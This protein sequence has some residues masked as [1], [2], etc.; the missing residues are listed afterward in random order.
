MTS[1]RELLR[2][3]AGSLVPLL[4]GPRATATEPALTKR[5]RRR[6]ASRV[7]V[8]GAG[9]FGGWTALNLAQRGATVTLIDAWGAG[10]ARAS[11]GGETR[12]I[13][14]AYNGQRVYIEMARRAL[15]LWREYETAWQRTVLHR[16]G[17]LWMFETGDDAFARTSADPMREMRLM[18]EEV[19]L[20]DA[21]KRFPQIRTDGL[22][23]V[24]WE[25]DA[26]YLLAREACELVRA[27]CVRAGVEYLTG[28]ANAGPISSER[29][30][31]VSLSD[32]T[33]RDADAFVF[34]CGPWLG[35]LF[36]D[37]LGWRIRATKQDV[38]YFGTPAGDR[39]FDAET[40]PVWVNLG[41][42]IMYGIPGN[43][44]R[45]FKIA[46]D[47]LGG[48]VD[49]TSFERTVSPA[50]VM[51]ARAMLR[52]R[53]PLLA[54]APL[55]HAEVCQYE[56]TPDGHYLMDWHPAARN[57]LLLGGGSGHGFKMGPAIGEMASSL[58]L[59]EGKVVPMF[60]YERLRTMTP[61]R[62][63]VRRRA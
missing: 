48:D 22:Q 10:N 45:G 14:A 23:R 47:S 18:L 5:V 7:V 35:A 39:Q 56:S 32:G 3:C 59:S 36:P 31:Y 30:S 42:R 62:R 15:D 43:E 8:V 46:D 51:T 19:S 40:M 11:S 38:L 6:S 20:A 12:V 9:A 44:R 4:F 52:R 1:R 58:V 41:Q 2:W 28:K 16:T 21:A 55:V 34:A 33:R 61:A 37:I 13:R 49:P 54:R 25:S 53:F 60:A 24:W 50:S 57:V 29:M 27:A 63:Y 26:G 17:A